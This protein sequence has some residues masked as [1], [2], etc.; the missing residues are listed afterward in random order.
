[1][2]SI[3]LVEISYYD[4][5]NASPGVIRA[6]SGVGFAAPDAP[7]YFAP[8]I[9]VDSGFTLDREIWTDDRQFGGG[10]IS[11]GDITLV[12][13]RQDAGSD[14]PYD[15]L[16]AN[17]CAVI[18]ARLLVVD[19][20]GAYADAAEV[21]T[22]PLDGF[23]FAGDGRTVSFRWRDVVAEL[24]EA[25]AQLT[26]FL[27]N[28]ALP[29]GVEGSTDIK[30][31]WKPRPFGYV[32]NATVQCVN[33]SLPIFQFADTNA[34]L[35]PTSDARVR[36]M[37][38]GAVMT[39]GVARASLA[40]LL[41]NSAASGTWDYY[42]GS[43]GAFARPAAAQADD[44]AVTMDIVEGASTAARTVAQIWKRLLLSWGVP[45]G[46]IS[47]ADITALDTAFPAEA[48]LWLGADE[49][50]RREA[51]DRIA[52]T[53][54]AIYWRDAGGVWRIRQVV[55][56]SGS[57]V[58]TFRRFG[59]EVATTATD[60]DII[61]LEI[62]D[63]DGDNGEPV[64]QVT[65]QYDCNWTV[66]GRDQVYGATGMDLVRMAF[67]EAEWRPA[68]TPIDTAVATAYPKARKITYDAL[69]ADPSA[70]AAE[71]ARRQALLGGIGASRSTTFA[72]KTFFDPTLAPLIRE[73]S[74]V[75][76]VDARYGLAAGRLGIVTRIRHDGRSSTITYN[77]RV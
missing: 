5:V 19:A 14:Y 29:A 45:S 1:M 22:G 71:A 51:L 70:A 77:V 39:V 2:A 13:L 37:I 25:T 68:S 30:G 3:Y 18:S 44:G 43:E 64:Q 56:P 36:L 62:L 34:A 10:R 69:I 15:F 40:A 12:A 48:N 38:R 72:I 55:A 9:D 32:K 8:T 6:S 21:Y 53:A 42:I 52:A 23:A 76:L 46:N 63:S 57:P 16:Q 20:D 49:V 60:L 47:A 7:G 27:G 50:K 17:G 24:V 65:L 35:P 31:R 28:N 67:L 74:V 4:P 26:Q 54:G 61:S 41:A 33:T 11:L 59:P 75:R 58:A 66:Q 73:L